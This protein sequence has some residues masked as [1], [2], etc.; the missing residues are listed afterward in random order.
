MSK[1]IIIGGGAA[2]MF[3]A[4]GAVDAGHHVTILEQ[5]EKLGKKIYITG[6]G[7]CNLTNACETSEIFENIP[8]NAKFLYSAIYGYDNFR[9]IDFFE[10][11]GMPTKTERG[12][13]VFPVSDHSSDVIATLQRTL[14]NKGVTVRLYTKAEH[15]EIEEGKVRGVKTS[16]GTT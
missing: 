6:K 14:K 13:R 1:V 10:E 5:N 16:N 2:G 3:A 8:R 11:H 9:V 7:R 15:L 4:L 12:N